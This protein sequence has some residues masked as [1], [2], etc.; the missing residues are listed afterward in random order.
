[1]VS[2]KFKRLD[3]RQ[4][5]T[6]GSIVLAG[7]SIG[8]FAKSCP[9]KR[10]LV[11][12]T[13]GYEQLC[14]DLVDAWWDTGSNTSDALPGIRSTDGTGGWNTGRPNFNDRPASIANAKGASFWQQAQY[15]RF[16]S[17]DQQMHLGWRTRRS[18]AQITA[19]RRL[20]HTIYSQEQLSGNGYHDGTVHVSD[21]AAW[22]I[23]ALK[24]IHQATGDPVD[25]AILRSATVAILL[26]YVDT[27]TSSH[28][29]V[30]AGLTFSA[31]G[32]LYALPE[33]DPNGQGRATTY[34][35]GIMDAALYLA[36]IDSKANGAF[37]T[38]VQ[39]VYGNFRKTLQ[40]PSGIYFQTLQLDPYGRY[41][42]T[43]FLTPIEAN[44]SVPRQGYDGVTI[45]GTMGMAVIAAELFR[46]TGQVE[47]R[48][49]VAHIVAGIASEY[50]QNGCIL[51]DHDPWTAGVWGYDFASRALAL[52][53]VDPK[54]EVTAAILATATR[55]L[56]TRTSIDT[57]TGR[58]AY[59]YSAE[60][61]GN[62]ERSIR[63]SHLGAN[64]GF[65][66]WASNGAAANA[67]RGGGQATPNQIMT[68][69]S[70]GIMVQAAVYLNSR[71]VR[72]A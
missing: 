33:Q 18:T 17:N 53:D 60:W 25:L 58:P 68:A 37:L 19:Q 15:L 21:D 24:A 5:L 27:F 20:W 35:T 65:A 40:K 4:I 66:S 3:R 45:G 70:S 48:Q 71:R 62:T 61:S 7:A 14:R 57:Y 47:Y 51:C 9:T 30:V 29:Q 23:Q 39:T 38:Y 31:F 34:E 67:G 41:D 42:A 12:P 6:G 64:D 16:L 44:K 56:S 8:H 63:E 49:D 43:P 72:Q 26:L 28:R 2:V 11:D 13:E 50:R 32:C 54:G 36:R 1:M 46:Q 55:I 22:K 10:A 59:G 69:S 52:A